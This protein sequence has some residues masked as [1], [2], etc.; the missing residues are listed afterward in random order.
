[1]RNENK[2]VR[3]SFIDDGDSV[4]FPRNISHGEDKLEIKFRIERVHYFNADKM[5]VTEARWS[6]DKL[7]GLDI[8][9]EEIPHS[10]FR[11]G[12]FNAL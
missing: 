4:V 8:T 12:L 9:W 2:N 11:P 1:L 7:Q 3:D 6:G 5:L 10:P